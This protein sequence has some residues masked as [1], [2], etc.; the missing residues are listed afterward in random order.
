MVDERLQ[1]PYVKYLFW[2]C[3]RV[4]EGGPLLAGCVCL[5]GARVVRVPGAEVEEEPSAARSMS[6]SFGDSGGPM[7]GRVGCT[8]MM[9]VHT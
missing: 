2:P 6:G 5:G 3:P 8:H 9:Y 7:A 4:W 1:L